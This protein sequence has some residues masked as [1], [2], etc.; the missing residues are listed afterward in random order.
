MISMSQ[1]IMSDGR[2]CFVVES[3]AEIMSH[4]LRTEERHT[5]WDWGP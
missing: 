4:T 1:L 2:F 5:E 3:P